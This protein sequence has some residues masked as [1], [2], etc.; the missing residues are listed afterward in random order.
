MACAGWCGPARPGGCCPTACHPGKPSISKPS[1]GSKQRGQGDSQRFAPPAARGGRAALLGLCHP[2]ALRIWWIS[3]MDVGHLKGYWRMRMGWKI[4][5]GGVRT[6]LGGK[7]SGKSSADRCGTCACPL[8]S[9]CAN[10]RYARW[11]WP[12]PKRLQPSA[13]RSRVWPVAGGE[14]GSRSKHRG[15]SLSVAGGWHPALSSR[16][17]PLVDSPVT[18][19]RGD[20]TCSLRRRTGRLPR[21]PAA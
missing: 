21:L 5:T 1:A 3:I 15:P 13:C 10:S 8:V 19:A 4:P 12:P 11:N 20:A 14:W 6:P 2:A 7:N 16:G 9:G 18:G 17:D